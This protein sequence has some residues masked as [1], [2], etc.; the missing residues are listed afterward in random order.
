[1]LKV[2]DRAALPAALVLAAGVTGQAA[3]AFPTPLTTPE[4]SSVTLLV[5]GLI[6]VAA[7]F[8]YK[9]VRARM[10]KKAESR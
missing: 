7:F 4:S 2:L 3:H 9:A 6:V 5:P 10:R 8:V 1:M